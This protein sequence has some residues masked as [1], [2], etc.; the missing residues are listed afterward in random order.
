MNDLFQPVRDFETKMARFTGFDY[1]VAVE[2]GSA[3]IFLSCLYKKVKLVVIPKNTYPSVP[4]SI[5]HAGGVVSFNNED[6]QHI[7]YYELYS[8]GIYD[9]ARYLAK[10]MAND[11]KEGNIVCLSFHHKKVLPIGR[12]GMVLTN[13]KDAV[14]WLKS[15]RHDG[16][17]DG[18]DLLKDNL[19]I[20]GWNMLLT[21]EQASRGIALMGNLKSVNRMEHEEYPD[22]S[23]FNIW[24]N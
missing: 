9:S 1:G 24:K 8:S 13:N 22:L 3:A 14:E 20:V 17:H 11:F 10:N 18:V 6:W 12:G 23:R 2:S 4:A 15:A 16:R 19:E 5:V 7:G 21:P